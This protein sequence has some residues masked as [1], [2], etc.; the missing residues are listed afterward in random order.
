MISGLAKCKHGIVV[1]T[2]AVIAFIAINFFAIS[3]IWAT[4]SV[5]SEEVLEAVYAGAAQDI[6][7]NLVPT[8]E[9]VEQIIA[10]NAWKNPGALVIAN[11]NNSVNVRSEASEA[12][13]KAGKLYCDCGGYIIEYTDEW[14]KIQ[15]G[16]LVGWVYNDY[17]YFGDEAQAK[18]D[19]VGSN[20]ATILEDSVRVR[21]EGSTE[22]DI[23]DLVAKGDAFEVVG[24]DG[25]WLIVDYEGESGY[26]NSNL[27]NVEF[28][29]DSGETMAAIE[30]REAAEKEAQAKAL[31]AKREA[32]R[33]QYYGV[34]A[35][36]ASDVEILGALIQCESGNQPYEGQVAVGAVVMNRL[37]SGAY[38][39][40]IYGVIYASGQFTPARTGAVDR[41][42][43]NGV[44][45]QCLQAA[46]EAINGYSPVGAATHF[47]PV[48]AHEG[49]VIGGHVFW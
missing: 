2:I 19:E 29:I 28:I 22:S 44:N 39:S 15:S 8:S 7:T 25:E 48:G 6:E 30:A 18:A 43:A 35:A 9:E 12:S 47:R 21:K 10:D 20:R 45:A 4:E 23:I 46:Q 27:A 42:I 38:P 49:I 3:D 34:Y 40:T 16:D 36:E 32:E 33:K 37:R 24:Y 14:T 17:L 11:C 26:I 31:A 1:I 13:D 5:S 41:R